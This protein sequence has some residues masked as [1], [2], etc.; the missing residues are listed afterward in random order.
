MMIKSIAYGS[1]FLFAKN[2]GFICNGCSLSRWYHSKA[3]TIVM[4][5]NVDFP[6]VMTGADNNENENNWP[7]NAIASAML[8]AR[9]RINPKET[10][11]NV[12]IILQRSDNWGNPYELGLSFLFLP[13]EP[14]KISGRYNSPWYKPKSPKDQLAPCQKPIMMKLM[15]IANAIPYLL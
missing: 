5:S 8:S 6:A 7:A 13:K 1:H 12:V 10:S 3:N 2:D 9:N 15:I 11:M 4:K 14:E